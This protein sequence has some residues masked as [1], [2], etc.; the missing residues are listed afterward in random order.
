LKKKIAFLSLFLVGILGAFFIFRPLL[1]R[2]IKQHIV[3]VFEESCE[4]CHLQIGKISIDSFRGPI[5]FSNLVVNFGDPQITHYSLKIRKV[6]AKVSS[7][8]LIRGKYS[9]KEVELFFPDI[10]IVDGDFY[11][12]KTQKKRL[13]T[14]F[15]IDEIKI[16]D[17]NFS[18][19]RNDHG[20]LASIQLK[21]IEAVIGTFGNSTKLAAEETKAEATAILEDSGK[22]KVSISAYVFRSPLVA[23][24]SLNIRHQNL[25]ELNR[26]FEKSDAFTL[27]GQLIEGQGESFLNGN[28]LK[29]VVFAKYEKLN[30]RP[31][32]TKERSALSALLM[33]VG[34]RL[35]I[36]SSNTDQSPSEQTESFEM[37]RG[38]G[39]L[40]RFI[41]LGLKGAAL[42]IATNTDGRHN[43]KAPS[44]KE[45]PK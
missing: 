12:P 14:E 30:L 1:G 5:I 33:R 41:L 10:E 21:N 23:R 25:K 31:F 40:V 45:S 6:I 4:T 8:T 20:V 42:K 36:D 16:H 18:Y 27:S 32:K 43:P 24:V 26:Y 9:I 35:F 44:S 34:S 17:G 22:V 29:T 13:V 2:V 7:L 39:S 11:S 15:N 3:N 38:R 28:T 19:T 37:Q